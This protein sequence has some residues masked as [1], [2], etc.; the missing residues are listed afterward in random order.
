MKVQSRT[1]YRQRGLCLILSLL[2]NTL[3]W[4]LW[5]HEYNINNI[6]S[7]DQICLNLGKYNEC[8]KSLNFFYSFA[9]IASKIQMRLIIY[10]TYYAKSFKIQSGEM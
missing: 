9:S 5:Q 2:F 6:I 1:L 3:L 4:L 7:I 10:D 8:L